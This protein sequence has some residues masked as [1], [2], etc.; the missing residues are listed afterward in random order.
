[1]HK[2]KIAISTEADITELA[3]VEID[4]KRDS[5]PELVED[6]ELD[7][8]LR[9]NRWK[10]YFQRQSPQTSKPERLVLKAVDNGKI[11]C[12]IAGHLT[13]RYDLEA[14]IQSF[15]ILK[16][17]QRQ[18]LGNR[19]LLE[20]FDWLDKNHA[21]S[22]CV[23]IAT[24]NKYKAFYLKNG[25]QYLNEHWIYWVDVKATATNIGIAKS[26]AGRKNNQQ[27]GS[28]RHQLWCDGF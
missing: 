3:R 18:G 17:Y 12:Y 2:L 14:E 21:T 26:G 28:N 4:S 13:T 11:V 8:E 22:L 16:P 19:L 6:F 5:I 20:F 7:L 24:D 1:M 27:R 10:T 9:A 25:G 23:G 15:Y